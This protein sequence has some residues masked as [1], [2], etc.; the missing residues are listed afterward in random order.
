MANKRSAINTQ[1]PPGLSFLE[2]I[3]ITTP[4]PSQPAAKFTKKSENIVSQILI[5]Y[6]IQ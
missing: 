1:N 6:T 3:G 2:E 5:V 4:A